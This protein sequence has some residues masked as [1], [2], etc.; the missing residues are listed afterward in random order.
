[1]FK[2]VSPV[3]LFLLYAC[4][5]CTVGWFMRVRKYDPMH[6]ARDDAAASY[7]IPREPPGPPPEGM[8]NQF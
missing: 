1:M 4:V 6:R 2:V 7:W 5:F 3:V 8:V